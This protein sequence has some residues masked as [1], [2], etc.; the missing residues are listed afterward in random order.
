MSECTR[1][2]LRLSSKQR[3]DSVP[4]ARP[5]AVSERAIFMRA[6]HGAQA[7]NLLTELGDD[8]LE[9]VIV[10]RQIFHLRLQLGEPLLFPLSTFESSWKCG[11]RVS[12]WSVRCMAH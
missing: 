5:N 8:V 10:L 7:G 11:Q 1:L 2:R 4:I 9:R 3:A 12:S 6:E